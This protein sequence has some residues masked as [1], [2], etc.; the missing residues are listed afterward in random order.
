EARV[1]LTPTVVVALVKAGHACVIESNA[2]KAA[3][4]TNAA[5]EQAG[6]RIANNGQQVLQ[7]ANIACMVG[8]PAHLFASNS[9]KPTTDST[10]IGQFGFAPATD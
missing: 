5:Y 6:A 3:G 4:F 1:A 8:N 2:G 9:L 7:E 10:I